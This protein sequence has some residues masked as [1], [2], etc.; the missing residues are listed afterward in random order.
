MRILM[1]KLLGL[2]LLALAFL[3][4]G[5]ANA[6]NCT[7]F[8]GSG[9]IN[10]TTKWFAATNGTG[11][12]CA[13]A[14]GWPNSSAD[15]AIFDANSGSGT[16][17]RNVNWTV[18]SI[19]PQASTLTIGNSTDTATVQ[20]GTLQNSAATVRVL[21]MGAS[22]WTCGFA[23]TQSCAWFNGG[24]GLTFNANTS[25]LVFAGST[26]ASAS[27]IQTG[28]FTYNVVTFNPDVALGRGA[29]WNGAPTITTLN[30]GSPNYFVFTQSQTTTI[31]NLNFTGGTPSIT[32]MVN[33]TSGSL[34]NAFT[35]SL[36]NPTTCNYC[37]FKDMTA[38]TSAI[39][40][41][42]SLNFGG[43]MNITAITPPSIGGGGGGRIM[44][45]ETTGFDRARGQ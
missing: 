5:V 10:D 19:N 45:P 25:T 40:G 13:A 31:T 17:T 44:T 2:F 30:I 41:T 38:T 22:T 43:N 9:N 26:T 39:T 34:G 1:N 11:G 36:A 42:N 37:T 21:N 12:A 32:A 4:P 33:F 20:V 29:A 16:I 15:N 35:F 28:N 7:W 6:T 24:A 14:G 18:G 8:S 23:T 3:A 27:N